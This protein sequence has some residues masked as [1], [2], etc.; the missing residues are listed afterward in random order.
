M[1]SDHVQLDGV[2]TA[3][4]VE[5]PIVAPRRSHNSEAADNACGLLFL[6]YYSLRGV[7]ALGAQDG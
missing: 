5:R 6:V 3:D 7:G 2:I 4:L 1:C